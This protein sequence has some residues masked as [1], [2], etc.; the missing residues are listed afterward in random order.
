[1]SWSWLQEQLGVDW[2]QLV[3]FAELGRVAPSWD[4]GELHSSMKWDLGFG[5]R[6]LAKGLLV[7]LDL[8]GSP[9]GVGV[10]MMV[11]HPFQF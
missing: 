4:L 8:A 6:A 11:D 2:I 10:Q 5:L 9:E 7:R 1:M 3:P